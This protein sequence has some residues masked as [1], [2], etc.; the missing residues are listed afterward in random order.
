MPKN[1][2]WF[3]KA[4]AR[5]Q[6]SVKKGWLRDSST[7]LW[8]IKTKVVE[9]CCEEES[10]VST[11]SVFASECFLIARAFPTDCNHVCRTLATRPQLLTRPEANTLS[12]LWIKIAKIKHH[13]LTKD[14]PLNLYK[15]SFSYMPH[16]SPLYPEVFLCPLGANTPPP[17]P[18]LPSS[19]SRSSISFVVS[20]S[21]PLSL[22]GK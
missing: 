3:Q 1:P 7:K 19:S 12:V 5:P 9:M 6:L 14:F 22:W 10:F 16:L 8:P 13:I 20:Y 11:V 4:K 2:P 15:L 21:F 17:S 18:L